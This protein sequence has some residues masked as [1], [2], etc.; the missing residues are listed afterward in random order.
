MLRR[1][2]VVI[3]DPLRIKEEIESP[4]FSILIEQGYQVGGSILLAEGPEGQERHRL[5]LIM[6]PPPIFQA[7]AFLLPILAALLGLLACQTLLLI[8][9]FLA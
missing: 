1:P 9:W 6:Q 4:A 2:T 3:I 5:A 7:P 8:V